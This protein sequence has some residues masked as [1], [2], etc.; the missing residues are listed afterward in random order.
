MNCQSHVGLCHSTCPRLSLRHNMTHCKALLLL[1]PYFY[2]YP[3]KHGTSILLKCLWIHVMRHEIPHNDVVNTGP[4]QNTP[5]G[6]VWNQ[7]QRFRSDDESW[8]N[9]S[10]WNQLFL[11]YHTVLDVC[12]Q[13]YASAFCSSTAV[14]ESGS[15]MAWELIHDLMI[16]LN[17]T[18]S[19]IKFVFKS[20]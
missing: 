14:H 5:K 12:V 13:Y 7:L 20:I 6:H 11:V 17:Y 4:N 19:V 18:W 2:L 1:Y 9:T 10:V 15:N 16:C 8:S 3:C